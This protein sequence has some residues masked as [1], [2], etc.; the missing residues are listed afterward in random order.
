MNNTLP[1]A[2]AS[3]DQEKKQFQSTSSDFFLTFA[4]VVAFWS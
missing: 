4:D 2:E 3:A 1:D